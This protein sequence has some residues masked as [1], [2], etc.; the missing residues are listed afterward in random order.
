MQKMRI[1]KRN[2]RSVHVNFANIAKR[3]RSLLEADWVV[4]VD[5]VAQRVIGL[6]AD[7][8]TTAEIDDLLASTLAS[9]I[10]TH[11]D[12]GRLAA[13]VLLSK[14]YK[15]TLESASETWAAMANVL[16]PKFMD[17]VEAHA[18]E[19]DEMIV[20]TRDRLFDYFGAATF[21]KLY[22]LTDGT[23]SSERPQHVYARVAIVTGG[24]DMGSVRRVYDELSTHRACFGS[25]TLFNAGLITQQMSSCFLLGMEDSIDGIFESFADIARV[26]KH[27]GGVGIHIGDVRSKGARI[28]ST[29]GST[30]GVV[31]LCRVLNSIATYVNQSN[32]R[33][34]AIAVY[35]DVHHPDVLDVIDLRR[36][37]GDEAVRARDIFVGLLVPDLFMRRLE[38][39]ELWSFFDAAD[40]P[41]LTD[42]VGDA[43]ERAYLAYEAAG[44][45]K[46]QVPA[47]EIMRRITTSEVESGVPYVI[48]KDAANL[49]SNQ[50]HLGT[51]KCS[52]LCAEILEFS[53]PD[54][55][56]VCTLGS[57]CLPR[58]VTDGRLDFPAL[59]ATARTMVRALDNVIDVNYAPSSKC[60]SNA[61]HR[62]IGLG[63]QGL[64][65]AFVDMGHPFDSPEAVEVSRRV[66]AAIYYAAIDESAELAREKGAHASF[67][68]SPASRGLLQPDLWDGVEPHP[69]FEWDA[70]RAKAKAGL[71]NSLLIAIMPTASTAQVC[72]NTESVEAVTS[73]MYLRRTLSGEFVCVYD[74]LVRRLVEL[75]KWNENLRERLIEDD[76]SIQRMLDLPEDVRRLFVTAYDVKQRWVLDHAAARGPYVCQTQSTNL[77]FT[78]PNPRTVERALR[79]GWK[80]GLKTG[81]YYV[82]GRAATTGRKLSTVASA[83]D[84]VPDAAEVER[85]A[86]SLANPG[87]CDMCSG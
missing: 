57:I 63:V 11:P 73:L 44:L 79:Y 4:D 21:L 14:K 77:F 84:S 7:G 47:S 52:N 68:G 69:D 22:T 23:T 10:S 53:R 67:A 24:Y 9:L 43:Y 60:A 59:Q 72:G 58:F 48:Y 31:P 51:I 32:R 45:A 55:I 49:K 20:H 27:G 37:G 83:V 54:E 25:P 17:F 78:D 85:L 39:G 62:P 35:I 42:L 50:Q 26:S 61:R 33:K 38:A 2:G 74:R 71:R 64:Y 28:A 30:D 29:N 81:C 34:G 36:P 1:V 87:A 19:L 82:R 6:V 8:M 12:H 41:D 86:C 18:D 5:R 76:G 16:S 13:R 3:L 70:L 56:A 15:T 66:A 80:A 40:A 75:G 46:R 65:D